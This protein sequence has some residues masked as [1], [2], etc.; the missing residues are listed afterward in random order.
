MYEIGKEECVGHIQKR[1]GAALRNFKK[2]NKGVKLSDG[3]SV[4]GARRLTDD[5]IN[6][7]QNY[8]GRNPLGSVSKISILWFAED[9]DW[10]R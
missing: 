3:K 10:G 2:K 6:R 7:I 1:M 8:F 9:P 5:C 4:G